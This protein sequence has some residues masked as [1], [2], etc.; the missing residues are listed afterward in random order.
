MSKSPQGAPDAPDGGTAPIY[1]AQDGSAAA[2]LPGG[3]RLVGTWAL[4]DGRYCFDWDNGPKNSCTQLVRGTVGFIVMDANLNE[5]RWVITR[6]ATG[7]PE[8]L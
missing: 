6:L 3:S 1:Y 5:P 2:Q 8:Q 4:E 7:N